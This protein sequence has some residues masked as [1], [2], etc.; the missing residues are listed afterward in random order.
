M[1]YEGPYL[2]N[3]NCRKLF[4]YQKLVGNHSIFNRY[5]IDC[6]KYS[7]DVQ[8]TSYSLIILNKVTELYSITL[9]LQSKKTYSKSNMAESA[10]TY[11]DGTIP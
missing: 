8:T 1:L 2:A 5:L 7:S 4:F 11:R 10:W 6:R 9:K 3:Q